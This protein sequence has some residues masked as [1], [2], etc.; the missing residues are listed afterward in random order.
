[1]G[2]YSL[3]GSFLSG[4]IHPLKDNNADIE[5]SMN[6]HRKAL[7]VARDLFENS[8]FGPA[9]NFA[10]RWVPLLLLV[11][12]A[13]LMAL[14]KPLGAQTPG[15]YLVNTKESQ[16]QIHLF[17]GGFLSALGGNHVIA[18]TH[19]SGKVDLSRNDSWKAK[20]SGDA[21]SLKV[22]DPWGSP[23]ERKEVQDIML[24]PKQLDV[25]HFPSIE[26]DSL[27]FDPTSQDSIWHLM[28]NFELHG[29]TRKGKFSL[30]C[31]QTGDRLQVR[32]KKMVKL[33]DFNIQPFS[34]ALGAVKIKNDFEVVY[35]IILDRIDR[36]Q[37]G[38]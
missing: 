5:V 6:V 22:I 23:S 4:V 30:N 21:T 38:L 13:L 25:G 8:P 11:L 17:K 2:A 37:G 14:P 28:A 32:G 15:T 33:T 20:L 3:P 7:R 29:V 36:S 9:E 19:F 24:G 35:N 27:S 18:L 34:A 10:V 1:M 16:I 26:L 12:L 31:L